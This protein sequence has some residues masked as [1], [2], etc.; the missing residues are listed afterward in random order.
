VAADWRQ[1][2][3]GLLV[4]FQVY[5]AYMDESGTHDGSPVVAVAGY[6]ASFEQWIR[7]EDE[8]TK[9]LKTFGVATF[10][11]TDFEARQGPFTRW[12]QER[13]ERF[14]SRLINIIVDYTIV[15]FGCAVLREQ[16]ECCI[17]D[18]IK[19]A[20]KHPYYYCLHSCLR[21]LLAFNDEIGPF[22]PGIKFLFDRKP[23]REGM[24]TQMYYTLKDRVDLLGILGDMAFG[25]KQEHIPLQASDLLL[26]EVAKRCW[27][28]YAEPERSI[29]KSLELLQARDEP[30]IAVPTEDQL[31]TFA[32]DFR[33]G[34]LP[35]NT[36]SPTTGT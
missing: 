5:N 1:A 13:R 2:T 7:L 11:M 15:G 18:D 4:I 24:A 10:H 16:Y 31:R 27:H 20:L 6:I 32:D 19:L 8:W 35:R 36:S 3:K 12:P 9:T 30:Y 25:N 14:L 33:T 34:W 17:P 23:G 28:W 21:T 26:Y 29:R 22:P